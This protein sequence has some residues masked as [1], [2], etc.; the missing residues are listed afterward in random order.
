MR[1]NEG[2]DD[3]YSGAQG[4]VIPWLQP[5]LNDGLVRSIPNRALALVNCPAGL[6][7]KDQGF[8]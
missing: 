1:V 4:A 5:F 3:T 2:G 7:R 8:F 6:A